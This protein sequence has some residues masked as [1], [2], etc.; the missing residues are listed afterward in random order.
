MHTLLAAALLGFA[1]ADGPGD[2]ATHFLELCCDGKFAEATAQ[3]SP[4]VVKALPEAKL[5]EL[6]TAVIAKQGALKSLGEPR[7]EKITGITLAKVRCEFSKEPLDAMVSITR[8]GKIGGLSMA[9]A[10][11]IEA[12]VKPPAYLDPSKY[13]ES[14]ITVGAEGWPL[15]G[16][17]T[18]PKT[19]KGFPIVVLVHGSGP[20]DRDEAIGSNAPFRDLARGLAAKGIASIR[21]DK[22]TF[23]LKKKLLEMPK[24][25][26]TIDTEVIDDAIATLAKARTLPMVDP[27]RAYVIGHSLGGSAGPDIAKRASSYWR[28]P[29]AS[30]TSSSWIR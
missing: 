17:L 26:I 6:W 13:E 9:P 19:G 2:T 5:K 8:E 12:A 16:T 30:L 7:I 14:D 23:A 24:D 20:N 29:T 25:Y 3:F 1:V 22:R 18:V 11:A 27:G 21:Y 10:G 28:P 4:E 15:P